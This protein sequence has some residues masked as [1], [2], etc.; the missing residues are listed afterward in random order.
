MEN[1]V[2]ADSETGAGTWANVLLPLLAGPRSQAKP[3]QL[4]HED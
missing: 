3:G 1:S 4:P 2:L